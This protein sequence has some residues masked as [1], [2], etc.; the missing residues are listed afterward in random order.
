MGE[1][2]EQE[3]GTNDCM[4]SAYQPKEV[5]S[6]SMGSMSGLVPWQE[7]LEVNGRLLALFSAAGDVARSFLH[8]MTCT[9][10]LHAPWKA[11]LSSPPCNL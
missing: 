9:D 10:T 2:N 8:E 5:K 7:F 3:T 4:P 1:C 11:S 6:T